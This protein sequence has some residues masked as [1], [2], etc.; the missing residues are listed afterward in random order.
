[1][2]LN[3]A[4]VVLGLYMSVLGLFR[5]CDHMPFFGLKTS[6]EFQHKSYNKPL[7]ELN[8]CVMQITDMTYLIKTACPVAHFRFILAAH[9]KT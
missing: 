6:L 5:V 2:E 1:M 9:V 7:M 4:L 8:F 3:A